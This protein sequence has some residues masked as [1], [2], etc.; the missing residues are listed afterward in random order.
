MNVR[1]RLATIVFLVFMA[2]SKAL[3][4]QEAVT[5]DAG[6]PAPYSGTLLSPPAVAKI[7]ADKNECERRV[8]YEAKFAAAKSA[9]EANY[10]KDLVIASIERDLQIQK[11]ASDSLK[12]QVRAEQSKSSKDW[13]KVLFATAV[14]VVGGALIGGTVVLL[15]K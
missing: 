11:I 13:V 8:E 14:G 3:F 9:L 7:I 6:A 10:Q 4:G 2:F 12:E 1:N 5:L 15:A